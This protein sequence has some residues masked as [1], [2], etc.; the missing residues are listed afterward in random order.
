[1]FI[2]PVTL[3][4]KTFCSKL[5]CDL[6]LNEIDSFESFAIFTT[7]DEKACK[8]GFENLHINER[9]IYIRLLNNDK[10]AELIQQSNCLSYR[11]Q[12]QLTKMLL[13]N[14]SLTFSQVAK[15]VILP[16]VEHDEYD[17]FNN[18]E[19]FHDQASVLLIGSHYEDSMRGGLFAAPQLGIH[20]IQSFLKMA[21]IEVDVFDSRLDTIEQLEA[22]IQRNNYDI[23][24]FT[25]LHPPIDSLKL[26]EQIRKISPN[27]FLIAGGQGAAFSPEFILKHSPIDAIAIG[28]G[29]NVLLDIVMNNQ[30]KIDLDTLTD[31]KGLYIKKGD[32]LH[33]TGNESSYTQSDL[34]VFSLAI[35]FKDIEYHRY[36]AK[37][38]SAYPENHL[39]IMKAEGFTETI[40]IY[41]ETHCAM[42]CDFCSSTNF[43]DNAVGES[44]KVRFLSAEDIVRL[45]RRA[46]KAYPAVRAIYFNDDEFLFNRQ[47]VVQL[48]SDINNDPN[49]KQ[50][51]YICMARVD[52]IDEE[53]LVMM[54]NAGFGIISFGIESFSDK[55]L[56]DMDKKLKKADNKNMSEISLEAV[57]MTLKAGIIPRINFILFYPT[58]TLDDLIVNTE[59]AVKLIL[60]GAPPTYYTFVEPFPGARIMQKNYDEGYQYE[61][62]TLNSK[63]V[64][65][66]TKILP[67][68]PEMRNLALNSLDEHNTDVNYFKQKYNYAEGDKFPTS[69]DTLILFY[70]I[71]KLAKLDAKHIR[72]AIESLIKSIE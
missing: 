69:I 35:D 7:L 48:C 64:R 53:L 63:A 55:I 57:E 19:R 45:I 71:Y 25:I 12:E 24:G 17:G 15:T 52:N 16:I 4:K 13:S 33:F 20:R 22:Q 59:I 5:N 47:R 66:P 28:Y 54:K 3:T 1:M 50:L 37:V 29:E 49:L 60:K 21:G 10:K 44:Q 11:V 26:T 70:S 43:L 14:K 18:S 34:R 42:K 56:G 67:L 41:T 39:K 31:I 2:T 72:Q 6:F 58:I 32:R 8:I 9:Y 68:N 65:I 46:R 51:N 40:R 27:S 62:F 36:W 61:S 23:I 38:K 30:K